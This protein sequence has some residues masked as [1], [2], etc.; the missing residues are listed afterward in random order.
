MRSDS[1]VLRTPA[2]ADH[3]RLAP[4]ACGADRLAQGSRRDPFEMEAS[5]ACVHERFNLRRG[6]QL[7]FM[8][9][10]LCRYAPVCS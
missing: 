4:A 2:K 5:S 3:F 7:S 10:P 1:P 8:P 9:F 6:I